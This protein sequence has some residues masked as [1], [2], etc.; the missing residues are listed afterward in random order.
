M[1]VIAIA[2]FEPSTFKD[3]KINR[4]SS[5]FDLVSFQLSYL[6]RWHL[7]SIICVLKTHITSPLQRIDD[8]AEIK[9]SKWVKKRSLKC[10]T[11]ESGWPDVGKK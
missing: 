2:G 10:E 9:P 11:R 6:F 8:L 7:L 1:N 3:K 5:I 4:F